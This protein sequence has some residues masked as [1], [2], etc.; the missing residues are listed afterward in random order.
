MAQTYRE[1]RRSV[2]RE[3]DV[4]DGEVV[5]RNDYGMATA[6]RVVSFIGGIIISLLGLRFILA[7]LGANP[8]NAFANF[9]YGITHPFVVPFFG[10]FNYRE[11][12]G[13]GRFEFETIVAMLFWGFVT[14]MI[15]RLLTINVRD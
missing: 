7:L 10:L 6:A 3:P 11:Q 1:V 5:D 12:L 14:W 15:V 13:I 9:V 2:L 8:A 4:V